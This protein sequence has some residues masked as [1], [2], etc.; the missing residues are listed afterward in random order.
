VSVTPR[1]TVW[2]EHRDSDGQPD[3]GLWIGSEETAGEARRVARAA[4]WRLRPKAQGGDQCPQHA[5]R[6]GYTGTGQYG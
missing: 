2:C 5:G 1:W 4:G 3:C 6:P